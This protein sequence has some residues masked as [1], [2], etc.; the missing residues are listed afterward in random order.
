MKPSSSPPLALAV[1]VCL[2]A[3]AQD[4][5]AA[6]NAKDWSFYASA[7]GYVIPDDDSYVSPVLTADRGKLHLEARYNYEDL[8]TGSFWIG[9]NFSVGRKVT[10][11]IAPM[12]GSVFGRSNGIAP[13]VTGALRFGRFTLDSQS[14]YLF[15]VH[16]A[17]RFSYVWSEFS[18]APSDWFRAGVVAQRT[19]AYQTELDVQ[20][21]ILAGIS[22]N[23][24]DFTVYVLNLGWTEVTTVFALGIQ[25]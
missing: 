1:L 10:L 24:W 6:A 19:R 12:I 14:E 22:R 3:L 23:R 16:R 11:E 17:N 15:E 2:P 7:F 20:R 9:R 21:G 4:S 5:P 18:Y 13:G 8:R 25:F